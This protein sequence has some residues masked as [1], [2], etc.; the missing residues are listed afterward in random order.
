MKLRKLEKKISDS[1][2]DIIKI[3][4]RIMELNDLVRQRKNNLGFFPS[5]YDRED[6]SFAQNLL[7]EAQNNLWEAELVHEKLISK[8]EK[9]IK[10]E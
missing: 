5:K 2:N 8:Y 1:E 10:K 6:L 4:S 9:K 7:S 3:K